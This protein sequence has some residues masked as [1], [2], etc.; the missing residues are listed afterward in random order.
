MTA[1]VVNT[2]ER[3]RVSFYSVLNFKTTLH[4]NFSLVDLILVSSQEVNLINYQ[5]VFEM[6]N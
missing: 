4:K 5:P 6:W 3:N 2:F 1:T